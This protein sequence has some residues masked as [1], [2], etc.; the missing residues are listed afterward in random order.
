VRQV[1]QTK[2]DICTAPAVDKRRGLSHARAC[3]QAGG[4]IAHQLDSGARRR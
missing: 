1:S 4:A 3:R 2:A